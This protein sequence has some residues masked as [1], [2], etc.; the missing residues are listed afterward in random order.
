MQPTRL[1]V[2]GAEVDVVASAEMPVLWALRD[3]LGLT[4][5]KYGCGVGLCGACTIHLD[6]SA[7]R[8]CVTRLGDVAGRNVTTIEGLAADGDHPVQTAFLEL[9]VPQCGYCQPGQ[10][11]TAAGLLRRHP[12]PSPD[13]IT[14]AMRDV[15]CRCGTYRRIRRAI[16]LAADR[17]S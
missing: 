10:I 3:I 1:M 5:T 6:G 17:T 16:E 13:Q 9:N 11:M 4:G 15:L 8:A 2:N 7:T 12:R 14:E